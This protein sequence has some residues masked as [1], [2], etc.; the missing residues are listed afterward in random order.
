M[1]ILFIDDEVES[2]A[3]YYVS[4]LEMEGYEV[5]G[6]RNPAEAITRIKEAKAAEKNID[7]VVLDVLIP[8]TEDSVRGG[9]TLLETLHDL[10][11]G[12]PVLILTILKEK[13]I[14]NSVAEMADVGKPKSIR[15]KTSTPPSELCALVKKTIK[16]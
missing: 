1:R 4:A 12:V 13:Q 9:L 15:A 2:N 11:P 3:R 16:Q 5:L 8:S 6:A 14:R 7:L 10:L